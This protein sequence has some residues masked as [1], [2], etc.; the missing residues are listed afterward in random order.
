MLILILAS[1]LRS[2]LLGLTVWAGLRLAR[3]RDAGT[4]TMIWAGVL[5]ASF[6]MPFLTPLQ[7]NGPVLHLPTPHPVKNPPMLAIAIVTPNGSAHA[8]EDPFGLLGA[9][10]D[11]FGAHAIMLA[12]T[13]YGVI[14]LWNLAR[15]AT[16][17]ILSWRLYR[18]AKPVTE[19][20]ALA[21][22]IRASAAVESP[23]SLGLAILIPADYAQWSVAAR[24]AI[25]AHEI[26]HIRRGDFF[27]Q[28]L[29]LLYRALFWF[30]PLSW[31]LTARLSELAETASD[32]AAIRALSDRAG[33]AEILI[34][35][36][37]H[38]HPPAT[39]TAM[40][41]GH[42]IQRRID[43]ILSDRPLETSLALPARLAALSMLAL[44][45]FTFAA[46]RAEMNPP[47]YRRLPLMTA[48][49]GASLA[50]DPFPRVA[51]APPPRGRVTAIMRRVKAAALKAPTAEI[52][53][54]NPRAL[55]DEPDAMVLPTI[56]PV[57]AGTDG[58]KKSSASQTLSAV[59]DGD[60]TYLA[61][62]R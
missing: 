1:A 56:I 20:W 5:A 11:W 41:K 3:L 18:D 4:E 55:L 33:Y 26:S 42:D 30:N 8:P 61:Q 40:A 38:G 21:H 2:A 53:K 59:S 25:L 50:T 34:E 29:A 32:E 19:D 31:W 58:R 22:N 35:A 36:S 46:A 23:F 27:L 49:R 62:P 45:S 6:A 9:W 16:G 15:L 47:T 10:A 43:H 54:P 13:V 48:V 24:S 57:M 7:T 14:A 12:W 28:F 37:L 52:D 60:A 17:L 51:T 39:L 44:L